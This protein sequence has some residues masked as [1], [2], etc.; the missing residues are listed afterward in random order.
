MSEQLRDENDSELQDVLQKS[1]QEFAEDEELNKAL[2][3]S[4]NASLH[5]D[6]GENPE[7]NNDLMIAQM[8]Q[9]QYDKENDEVRS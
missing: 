7:C 4:L 2:E 3:L 1:K 6:E 9:M 5:D 8:L